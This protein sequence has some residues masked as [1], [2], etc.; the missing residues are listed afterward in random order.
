MFRRGHPGAKEGKGSG[1]LKGTRRDYQKFLWEEVSQEEGGRGF[2]SNQAPASG[3]T[4]KSAGR[5]EKELGKGKHNMTGT[6]MRAKKSDSHSSKT[7]P[8]CR[9]G[10]NLEKGLD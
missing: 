9:A 8:N 10:T 5:Q 3:P 1:A 2:K 6:T 7:A 4:A